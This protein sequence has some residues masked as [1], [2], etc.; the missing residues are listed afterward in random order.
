[1]DRNFAAA[2]WHPDGPASRLARALWIEIL[3]RLQVGRSVCK[4]RLARALWIEILCSA[5]KHHT[6]IVEARESLVDR[7]LVIMLSMSS[8][9][10]SRLARALWIEIIIEMRVVPC[11]NVEA[12]ESLVDLNIRQSDR[13]N[14]IIVEAR[15]SLVDRNVYCIPLGIRLRCRGSREPYRLNGNMQQSYCYVYTEVS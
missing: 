8:M 14:R 15:K 12:R 7:N 6:Y 5:Y 11:N 2:S 10:G 3:V 4:S 9:L 1:M 13:A